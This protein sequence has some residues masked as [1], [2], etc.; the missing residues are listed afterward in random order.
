MNCYAVVL[1][2]VSI[3]KYIFSS[4]KLKDNIGASHL[5]K[6]ALESYLEDALN[7]LFSNYKE[8]FYCWKE[9]P[10]K[11]LMKEN[12][13]APFEVGYIGGGNALLFFRDNINANAFIKE[14]T[15]SLLVKAPGLTTSVAVMEF[16]LDNFNLSKRN[17]F[18]KLLENKNRFIPQTVIPRHGI[19][20]EC[21]RSGYSMEAWND[22]PLEDEEGYVST[23]IMAK[24]HGLEE[25]N[26][27]IQDDFKDI[28]KFEKKEYCF[29]HQLEN[30][31]HLKGEDSHIAVVHIDGNGMAEVFK[32]AKSV[33]EIRRLSIA[34]KKTTYE[35]LK[36]II[37]EKIVK[38]FER[39]MKALGFKDEKEENFPKVKNTNKLYIP[40]RPIIIG[41]DDITFVCNGK[42]GIYLAKCFLQKFEELAEKNEELNKLKNNLE[43]EPLSACAGIAITKTKFPF[44]RGYELAEQLCR[45]AKLKSKEPGNRGSWL[46]FHIAFGGFSGTLEEIKESHYKAIKGNLL[47]RPYHVGEDK[48]YNFDSFVD[49]TKKLLEDFPQSKI[50]E[51]REVLTLPE[52]AAEAFVYE[53]EA[54]GRKLPIIPGGI[55]YHSDLWKGSETPYFDIIEL[56]NFY[57]DFELKPKGGNQK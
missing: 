1:D 8:Y 55:S 19:T 48:L 5:V 49:A 56:I 27:K 10:D 28:L 44:Y 24:I 46:D 22:S 18:E 32:K 34:V 38:D 53:M 26:K 14:W 31:G 33:P 17:S 35:S 15:T 9:D 43:F 51:L 42:L 12:P 20:A 11:I 52:S 30:L 16:D 50:M 37:E 13:S 23:V 3:Q 41:G 21:S 6:E 25:A 2:T 39:I 40:I 36:K 29:P 7:A 45:S 54:Q 4:G 57:P 47:Y